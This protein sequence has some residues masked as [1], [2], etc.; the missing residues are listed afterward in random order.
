MIEFGTTWKFYM[1]INEIEDY[2]CEII[3]VHF[4][5]EWFD[6]TTFSDFVAYSHFE[7]V[8]FEFC[9]QT[10]TKKK[11]FRIDTVFDYSISYRKTNL[12]SAISIRE[13]RKK[14]KH[15][16]Y[17]HDQ[18]LNFSIS[19]DDELHASENETL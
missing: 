14:N 3:F 12:H 18:K 7:A 2:S 1:I 5:K 8:F 4:D 17:Y 19:C 6:S 16:K 13:I 11:Q 9:L 10:V 15:R